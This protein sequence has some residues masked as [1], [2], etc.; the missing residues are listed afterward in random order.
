MHIVFKC[1]INSGIIDNNINYYTILNNSHC[2]NNIVNVAAVS[3][4]LIAI[5][6][7]YYA[8]LGVG[9]N[10]FSGE[11]WRVEYREFFP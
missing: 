4:L 8:L 10:V 3:S 5:I 7:Q 9:I 6:I 1:I 2:C 11:L